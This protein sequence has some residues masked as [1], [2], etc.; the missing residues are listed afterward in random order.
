MIDE[1]FASLV[2]V[3][4]R[5]QTAAVSARSTDVNNGAVGKRLQR[6]FRL[7]ICSYEEPSGFTIHALSAVVLT[8]AQSLISAPSGCAV[9]CISQPGLPLTIAPSES[10]GGAHSNS[11]CSS[12]VLGCG[13]KTSSTA[14]P[15]NERYLAGILQQSDLTTLG[16]DERQALTC[17]QSALRHTQFLLTGLFKK[18]TCKG[19]EDVRPLFEMF[20]DDVLKIWRV[21]PIEWP[22]AHT[23]IQVLA[24]VLIQQLSP[25]TPN[26][27]ISNKSSNESS[28]QRGHALD[29]LTALAI[30]FLSISNTEESSTQ[31]P[32][33]SMGVMSALMGLLSSPLPSLN[34]PYGRNLKDP[35][36]IYTFLLQLRM[37]HSDGLLISSKRYHLALWL[38]ECNQMGSTKLEPNGLE[39]LRRQIV[40][41]LNTT[42]HSVCG[43]LPWHANLRQKQQGPTTAPIIPSSTR[44]GLHY[45]IYTGYGLS[46]R[47]RAKAFKVA[48]KAARLFAVQRA[49]GQSSTLSFNLLFG[50]ICKSMNEQSVPLR[51]RALRCV[52]TILERQPQLVSS[53][54]ALDLGKIIQSRLLDASNSVREAAVDLVSRLCIV[55]SVVDAPRV[56]EYQEWLASRVLDK[57]VSV[58]KRAIRFFRDYLLLTRGEAFSRCCLQPNEVNLPQKPLPQLVPMSEARVTDVCI[59]IVRRAHDEESIVKAVREMFYAL[60]LA[61]IK[62]S[63][64]DH[65]LFLSALD[66]RLSLMVNICLAMRANSSQFEVLVNF[67]Q[68]MWEGERPAQDE[69]CEQIADRICSLLYLNSSKVSPDALEQE[70]SL[71]MSRSLGHLVVLNMLAL[72]RPHSF[73]LKH[74]PGLIFLLDRTLRPDTGIVSCVD[75]TDSQ[76]IYHLISVIDALLS[77]VALC[78]HLSDSA[79]RAHL[80]KKLA[81][82]VVLDSLQEH[83]ISQAQRQGRC[84]VDASMACLGTLVNADR[85][86]LSDPIR[87]VICFAQFHSLL[88]DVSAQLKQYQCKEASLT[89]FL[90]ARLRPSLLRA[91]YAVGLMTKHISLDC[92][93]QTARQLT[94]LP[95]S[96]ALERIKAVGAEEQKLKMVWKVAKVG[97]NW[98]ALKE[99]VVT[100][101]LSFAGQECDLDVCKKALSGLVMLATR[102]QEVM[103]GP[104]TVALFDR[105]LRL[106]QGTVDLHSQLLE[107]LRQFLL[108]TERSMNQ[109]YKERTL[110]D[111]SLKQLSDQHVAVGSNVAQKYLPMALEHCLMRAE[112]L[113]RLGCFQF[114]ATILKQ[115]LMHPERCLAPLI[116]LQTDPDPA[117]RLKATIQLA[118]VEKRHPGYAVVSLFSKKLHNNN[119]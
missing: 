67:V 62:A 80:L 4:G 95:A 10:A 23:I 27:P 78:A 96:S 13:K 7:P 89:S 25:T 106:R 5:P 48:T 42:H 72:A 69:A 84:V 70:K 3:P 37:E 113:V 65:Q 110:K 33:F 21:A 11:S 87:I 108:E 85:P 1:L 116:C 44:R 91:L 17:Y 26:G 22:V 30:G 71:R 40:A 39:H 47:S 6:S 8:L 77:H 38:H 94:M 28:V 109:W 101:L 115:G 98:E 73:A 99:Q 86:L 82:P 15:S 107:L 64:D 9:P 43:L 60:W 59:K 103:Y 56:S 16:K 68:S 49:K 50:Y 54:K 114:I 20:M 93:F 88:V 102:Y 105:L 31:W 104:R 36:Q 18:L 2:V 83:L 53:Y 75:A 14:T 61:P 90:P 100:Q 112:M 63:P 76:H 97:S 12:S 46:P 66:E 92:I 111:E 35:T 117:L 58:R 55:I 32:G 119:T 118:E 19:E 34:S 79:T 45:C 24:N 74:T 29:A 52:T 81:D 41:E 51:T 57:G